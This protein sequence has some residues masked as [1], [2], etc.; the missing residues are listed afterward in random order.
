MWRPLCISSLTFKIYDSVYFL[1]VSTCLWI[2]AGVQQQLSSGQSLIRAV[3]FSVVK[4]VLPSSSCG[5]FFHIETFYDVDGCL[6]IIRN[7]L[8]FPGPAKIGGSV[9]AGILRISVGIVKYSFFSRWACLGWD[10]RFGV[11][12]DFMIL[13]C[14]CINCY[15]L[16][17]SFPSELCVLST[18]SS[19]LPKTAISSSLHFQFTLF[20]L[21]LQ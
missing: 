3:G 21:I 5:V 20:P 10:G 12:F 16:L 2:W 1:S 19:C 8:Y 18:K 17:P 15:S 4:M 6:L 9:L 7:V 13:F 11:S 14:S